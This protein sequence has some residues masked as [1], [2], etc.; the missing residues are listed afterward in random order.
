MEIQR[1]MEELERMI[2]RLANLLNAGLVQSLLVPHPVR[3]RRDQAKEPR[4]VSNFFFLCCKVE[5]EL[6]TYTDDLRAREHLTQRAKAHDEQRVKAEQQWVCDL[7]SEE[8]TGK[9]KRDRE[10]DDADA[11]W[12]HCERRD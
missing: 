7:L 8:R 3:R 5:L 6:A 2:E 4:I 1:L 9:A 11:R 12:S 10:D